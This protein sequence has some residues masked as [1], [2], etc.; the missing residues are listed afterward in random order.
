[1]KLIPISVRLSTMTDEIEEFVSGSELGHGRARYHF[2]PETSS[3]GALWLLLSARSKLHTDRLRKPSQLITF[4]QWNCTRSSKNYVQFLVIWSFPRSGREKKRQ[5]NSK[6]FS[7]AHFCFSSLNFRAGWAKLEMPFRFTFPISD[8]VSRL[9][10]RLE[11]FPAFENL[12]VCNSRG[13]FRRHEIIS[14]SKTDEAVQTSA[15]FPCACENK[16]VINNLS[17]GDGE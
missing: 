10:A 2:S 3:M 11:V 6:P 14:G 17:S 1:M 5:N 12:S 8:D 4:F 15:R 16:S 9:L 13:V 7:T